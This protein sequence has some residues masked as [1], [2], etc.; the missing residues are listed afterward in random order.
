MNRPLLATLAVLALGRAVAAFMPGT[1]IWSLAAARDL[2]AVWGWAPW[3]ED[4]FSPVN[5][6]SWQGASLT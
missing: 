4:L 6:R 3:L 1:W 5:T 2:D